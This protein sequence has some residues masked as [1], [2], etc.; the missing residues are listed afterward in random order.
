M[1]DV[2]VRILEPD[3][4][5][6]V[7]VQILGVLDAAD[8]LSRREPRFGGRH[9]AAS[10]FVLEERQVRRQLFGELLLCSAGTNEV[11]EPD[12]ETSHAASTRDS[13]YPA[14][15]ADP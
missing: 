9:P 11:V 2:P 3:K 6:R 8:G 1:P 12:Q 5:A 13:R 15:T 4:R 7:A 14:K 10:E